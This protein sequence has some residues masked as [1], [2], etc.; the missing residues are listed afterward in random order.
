MNISI[1][2]SY[3]EYII[4]TND[5]NIFI[6]DKI[7]QLIES[8]DQEKVIYTNESQTTVRNTS[9]SK[10]EYIKLLW[11]I[12]FFVEE[13]IQ[14]IEESERLINRLLNGSKNKIIKDIDMYSYQKYLMLKKMIGI[15]KHNLIKRFLKNKTMIINNSRNRI[16]FK[17]ISNNKLGIKPNKHISDNII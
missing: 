4:S 1:Y 10:I 6:E 12:P 8:M 5:N 17:R 9:L 14:K 7:R 16:I 13:D 2:S 11:D 15:D 3:G